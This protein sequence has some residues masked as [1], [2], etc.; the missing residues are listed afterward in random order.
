MNKVEELK[1]LIPELGAVVDRVL[2]QIPECLPSQLEARQRGEIGDRRSI[3]N[4]VS[5]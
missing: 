1:G 5:D 4:Y 2:V 3:L